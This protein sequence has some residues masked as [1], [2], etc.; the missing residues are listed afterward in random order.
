[1]EETTSSERGR[2]REMTDCHLMLQILLNAIIFIKC[3]NV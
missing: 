2:E 3:L 1:M